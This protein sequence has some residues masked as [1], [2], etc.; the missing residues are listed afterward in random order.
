MNTKISQTILHK[1]EKE[2]IKP[3]ARWY[4][5]LE[6]G[7]LWVPGILVTLL[8]AVAVAGIVYA[9]MHSGWEYNEFVYKTKV[10]FLIATT[11]FLWVISFALFNSLIV[12]ALR[13]THLGY[14]MSAKKIIIGSF[15]TSIILGCSV[16]VFDEKFEVDSLI[17]Y[18]VHIREKGV[19]SSP[20]QGRMSGIVEKK[21]EK[22]LLVR[23]F[24]NRLWIVDMSGFGS[25]TFPFVEEGKSIRVL[26]TTTENISIN[27]DVNKE[28]SF[29][30]CA[31]FPWEI[32]GRMHKQIPPKGEFNKPKFRLNNQN[33]DCESILEEMKGKVRMSERK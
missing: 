13:T 27:T 32:G 31:L 33:P 11:P 12:K 7:I 20:E 4:F 1:I 17:R 5:V 6:H 21:Y 9:V 16:Y 18:P 24:E 14:R 26:G 15:T 23:D 3:K 28:Y 19:W 2:N 22:A 29:V 10:D 8:G 25:T 30:A